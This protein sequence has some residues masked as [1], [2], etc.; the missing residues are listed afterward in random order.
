MHHLRR[1]MGD[2]CPRR[3]L[4][5]QRQGIIDSIILDQ[6]SLNFFINYDTIAWGMQDHARA[7]FDSADWAL[8]KVKCSRELESC[9]F[10]PSSDKCH[11]T[12]QNPNS[13]TMIWCSKELPWIKN[14]QCPWRHC[15]RNYRSLFWAETKSCFSKFLVLLWSLPLS[16][17]IPKPTWREIILCRERRTS[18]SP[19]EDPLVRRVKIVR[20]VAQSLYCITKCSP[21]W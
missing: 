1:S 3:S 19:L 20:W 6:S 12:N 4:W 13:I 8:C 2:S 5:L 7:F 17:E 11:Y 9:L 10:T 18:G 16:K 15:V 21:I 14:P